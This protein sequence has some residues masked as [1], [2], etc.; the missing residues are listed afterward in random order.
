MSLKLLL[1]ENVPPLVATELRKL[2]Y[3]VV[4]SRG[5]GLKGCKD[6]ELLAFAHENSIEA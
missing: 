5:M 2:G 3:D 6:P 4:H 1:D